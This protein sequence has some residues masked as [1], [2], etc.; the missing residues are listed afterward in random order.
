M[1]EGITSYVVVSYVL[2]WVVLLGYRV[3]LSMLSRRA[4]RA[5]HDGEHAR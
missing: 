2:A 5:L 1:P 3:R 4:E